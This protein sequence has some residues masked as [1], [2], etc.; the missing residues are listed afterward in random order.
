LNGSEQPASPTVLRVAAERPTDL[1]QQRVKAILAD[2]ARHAM[3]P[4]LFGHRIVEHL[5]DE[6]V[7][8]LLIDDDE[9][10][11]W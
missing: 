9:A 10:V 4:D 8:A 11:A 1:A 7:A 5:V 6:R 2:A 3:N